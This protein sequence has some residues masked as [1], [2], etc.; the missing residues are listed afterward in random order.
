[1]T[2]GSFGD[3]ERAEKLLSL[4][5]E[6][7]VRRRTKLPGAVELRMLPHD[8]VGRKQAA[9]RRSTGRSGFPNLELKSFR[10]PQ[11]INHG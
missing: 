4:I 5:L 10:S 1:V 8:I 6:L 9:P 3:A 11:E 7:G 2:F